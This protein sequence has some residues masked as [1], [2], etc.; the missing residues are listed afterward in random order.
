MYEFDKRRGHCS[1][2]ITT[3]ISSCRFRSSVLLVD[4]DLA[5]QPMHSGSPI[6]LVDASLRSL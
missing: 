1:D 5:A 6:H 2:A 4:S 3:S